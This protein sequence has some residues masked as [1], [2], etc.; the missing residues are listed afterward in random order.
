[1]AYSKE[2]REQKRLEEGAKLRAELEEK[3]RKELEEK[4]K[5]QSS[6][7][8][9]INEEKLAVKKN[10]KKIPLDTL[11]PCKSGVQGE[12]I[13]VSKKINGYQ[14]EWDSYGSVEYIELSELLSMRNTSRSFYVNN[15]IFFEDTDEYTALDFYNFLE[16]SKFYENTILG[17]DLDEIFSKSPEE[18]KEICSKLSR[19][20][21][22]TVAAKAKALIDSKELDST[23]RINALENVLGV[24]LNPSF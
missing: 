5:S 7:S 20:V 3:I 18:I 24:E 6:P 23:N 17:D 12:L 10:K 9:T 14:I 15:W 4:M 8:N 2:Q 22:D 21:K 16:V 11:V 1:M 19:G 13:Y